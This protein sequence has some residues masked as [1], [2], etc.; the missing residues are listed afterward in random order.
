MWRR[1]RDDV[2]SSNDTEYAFRKSDSLVRRVL[3]SVG[4]RWGGLAAFTF[5][6][7]AVVYV[8]RNEV[9]LRVGKTVSKRLRRLAAKVARGEE[10][11][12]EADLRVLAGWRWRVLAR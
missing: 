6:V 1:P 4:G 8:F 7:V 3:D 11:V 5:F 10:N 2:A 12:R 9:V